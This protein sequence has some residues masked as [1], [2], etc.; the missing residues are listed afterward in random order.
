MIQW[1]GSIIHSKRHIL[2]P[3]TKRPYDKQKFNRYV[4][5]RLQC[6]HLR[7]CVCQ[8]CMCVRANNIQYR[9][10]Q[11]R[12]DTSFMFSINRSLLSFSKMFFFPFYHCKT[13][14]RSIITL[15]KVF[16]LAFSQAVTSLSIKDNAHWMGCLI[17]NWL[18][19]FLV[20]VRKKSLLPASK[21]L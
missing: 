14:C 9:S 3:G 13:N 18:R 10:G 8:V 7:R 15:K 17:W 20:W 16:P 11:N 4:V 5:K 6:P 1:Y 12:L 19:S 21:R 2:M